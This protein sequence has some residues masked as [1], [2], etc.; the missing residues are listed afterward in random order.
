MRYETDTIFRQKF[1]M[2]QIYSSMNLNYKVSSSLL[3]TDHH[4]QET[5]L[6]DE[7]CSTSSLFLKPT[8]ELRTILI[9]RKSRTWNYIQGVRV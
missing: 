1:K 6:M 9:R 4:F 3:C 7:E 8:N 2:G 5:V